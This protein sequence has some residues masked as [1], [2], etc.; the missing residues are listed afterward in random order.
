MLSQLDLE[1]SWQAAVGDEFSTAGMSCLKDFLLAEVNAGKTFYPPASQLF[2]ALNRTPLPAVKVVILGQDPYYRPSQAH[3]LSFS[4]VTGTKAPKTLQNIFKE[5]AA[6]LGVA[7]DR[8]VC[9]EDWADQ[10]VLLLNSVLSVEAGRPAS[11]ANRGWERF[12]DRVIRAVSDR[13][14]RVAFLLWGK[15]GEKKLPLIDRERHLTVISA[16]PSPLSSY[17]G[18]FGS[19]PFSRINTFL[20]E[21]GGNPIVW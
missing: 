2:A 17:R 10:G 16:H 21:N 20:V 19:R 1:P 13:P 3:G 9:L 7:T 15:H 4:I 11:H 12:T 5:R 8:S 14:G 6:D 18:F